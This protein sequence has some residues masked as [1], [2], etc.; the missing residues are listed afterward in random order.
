M[1]IRAE[2]AFGLGVVAAFVITL[3][4]I[5]L[6][7]A[8]LS[9]LNLE[10]TIGAL[11][12][13]AAGPLT[14]VVGCGLHLLIGGILGLGYALC[15][16]ILGAAGW[17]RGVLLSGIHALAAGILLAAVPA[18]QAES[19]P[20]PRVRAPGF[21]ASSYGLATAAWFVAVHTLFGLI[22]GGGYHVR[23]RVRPSPVSHGMSMASTRMDWRTEEE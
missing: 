22:V 17:R 5:L 3:V 12:T 6:R 1:K 15:F 7:A 20:Y 14:W 16:E 13:G 4:M 10:M 2:T 18:V 19:S 21:M 8:D 23:D 9:R 11:V